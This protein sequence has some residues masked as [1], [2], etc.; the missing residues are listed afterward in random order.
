MHCAASDENGEGEAQCDY[1]RHYPSD[2]AEDEIYQ[3]ETKSFP[4]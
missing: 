2:T 4:P 3:R 1:D